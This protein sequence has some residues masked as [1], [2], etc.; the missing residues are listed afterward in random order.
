VADGEEPLL[1]EVAGAVPVEL[2]PPPVAEL[3]SDASEEEI[4][5]ATLETDEPT[6]PVPVVEPVVD[7]AAVVDEPVAVDDPPAAEPEEVAVPVAAL[8]EPPET[9]H[10]W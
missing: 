6:P 2:W 7:P 8:L 5:L 3:R 9:I 4:E 10:E 1:F